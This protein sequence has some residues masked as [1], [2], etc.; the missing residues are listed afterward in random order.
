MSDWFIVRTNHQQETVATVF[1]RMLPGVDE[2]FLPYIGR[3]VL[4][5]HRVIVRREVMF[6]SYLFMQ[7][8]ITDA[9]WSM[10][11]NTP[12][13]ARLMLRVGEFVPSI[14]DPMIIDELQTVMHRDGGAVRIKTD[15][16][17]T[18]KQ[19]IRITEGKYAG[20]EGLYSVHP[21]GRV[22]AL[23][24]LFNRDQWVPVAEEALTAA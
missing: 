9:L 13:V 2:L 24:R 4:T 8:K 1:L 23:I 21:S 22:G 12:G 5:K 18:D 19:R 10:V 14:V 17:F 20:I 16:D 6:P 15:R 7:A 11:N 3:K